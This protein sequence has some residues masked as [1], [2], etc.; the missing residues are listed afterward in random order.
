MKIWQ[1]GTKF[2][3]FSDPE[4]A[5]Q[6]A[7]AQIRRFA[8]PLNLLY[9]PVSSPKHV[10]GLKFLN[11]IGLAAGFDKNAEIIASLPAFG[12]G[13]AEIGTVT[14]LPQEGNPRPRLFRSNSNQSLF[15]RM[16]FN[17]L[18]S[19]VVYRNLS[20]A[21]NKLPTLFRVGVNLGKNRATDQENAWKDYKYLASAFKNIADYLVIN[22]SS[23][24]T[25]GLRDLQKVAHIK[26][27]VSETALALGEN[28]G[29][30]PVLVKLAPEML[31]TD[32][33]DLLKLNKSDGIDGWILTN[34]IGGQWSDGV[35]GGYSGG[36]L[37]KFSRESL[38]AARPLTDLPIISVG[39][40]MD[41]LE[42]QSRFNLGANL[43]QIYSSWVY[44]GPFFPREMAEKVQFR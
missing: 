1:L 11:P 6:I 31:G 36:K 27:I 33:V 23:P 18:G 39:G 30:V 28:V 29:K 13:F 40:I 26:K 4:D 16:G 12:F 37:T 20:A 10:M 5:H 38:I 8:R 21:K 9:K 24:N 22:V 42:A 44:K 2:L 43:I 35:S 34:T 15:N 25:I 14:P 7:I 3:F 32:L 17:S 19:D 41:T